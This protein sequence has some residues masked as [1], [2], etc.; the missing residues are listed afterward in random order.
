LGLLNLPQ[1][2][3]RWIG[4]AVLALIG[5][6]LISPAVERLLERPFQRLASR[7]EVANKGNGYGTGLALGTVFVP[8]AG[9]VLAAIIVAGSTGRIGVDTVLLTA[10]FAFGVS[11]PLLL[12]ALAGRTLIERIRV[13]RSRERGLRIAAGIAMIALAVGLAFN[14][15]QALQRLVPDYTDGL[16]RS[17][18]DSPTARKALEIGGLVNDENK[19]LS[20]C[21]A[22]D[23]R[24]ESCGPAPTLKGI[25]GWLN[26]PGGTAVDLAG[27]RG[28]VV[29]VDFWAYSCINCQRSIPHVV[30][31]DKAYRDHG[32][33]VIG[34]HSPEY[35]FEKDSANVAAGAKALGITYPVALDDSLA[36]WTNYRNRYWPADYLIDAKGVVRHIGFGE[37][38]YARTEEMIRELL[39]DAEPGSDLPPATELPDRTPSVGSTTQE[40]FLGFAKQRNFAGSLYPDGTSVFALPERQAKDTFALDGRWTIRAQAATPASGTARLRLNYHASVV[41]MVMSGEGTVTTRQAD[42]SRREI[43]VSGVPR[44]YAVVSGGNGSDAVLEVT[45]PGGVEVY[46]FAFG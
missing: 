10:S 9:P 4:I 26:T 42:G 32:L 43:E 29:L 40:T 23:G 25:S 41:Q 15:P 30:A 35:A 39:Q 16:Q 8:C 18:T 7:K 14:L 44:S 3:L 46:S 6:G 22:N 17:L 45:V 34:V 21:E 13:F 33:K 20:S 5:L 31:W 12:F 1:D 11:I 37:G 19:G 28:S 27:Q 2:A 24:L 38:D 36:T